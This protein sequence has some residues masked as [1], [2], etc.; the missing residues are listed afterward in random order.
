MRII[1]LSKPIQFNPGDP[2]FMQVR[3]RH[4]RHRAA[5]ALVWLLGLPARLF[6]KDFTGWADDTITKM[7]V[8]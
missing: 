3:I 5:K 2:R 4:K 8:H 1:D 6:P 7:G